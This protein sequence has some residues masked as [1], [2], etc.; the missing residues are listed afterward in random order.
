MARRGTTVG[1]APSPKLSRIISTNAFG[2]GVDFPDV[3]LV[4]HWQH[5]ASP[6]DY[7]QEFGPAG[8]DGLRSIA[9]LLTDEAPEGPAVK[10]LDFMAQH[11]VNNAT[12][13][14][15][16]RR[17]L[18]AENKRLLRQMQHFAFARTR[19][20]MLSSAPLARRVSR[21]A[22]RARCASSI[23]SLPGGSPALRWGPL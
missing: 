20:A 17:G 15:D 5:P 9:V 21:S 7:L 13:P 2:M 16:Q 1:L 8:R 6:E 22:T 10:L 14:P 11:T 19:F 4:I 23:G 18:L 12:V 3:R